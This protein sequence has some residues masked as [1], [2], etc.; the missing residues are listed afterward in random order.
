[1]YKFNVLHLHLT[2]SKGW[3]IDIPAWP[4]LT[5]IGSDTGAYGRP[6]GFLTQEHYRDLVRYAAARFITIVPEIDMPGHTGAIFRAYPELAGDGS[7]TPDTSGQPAML[8][9]LHPGHPQ[10]LPFVTD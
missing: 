3:R 8:Q 1:L 10:V 5:E 6:G 9:Y 2:D 7:S 4:K